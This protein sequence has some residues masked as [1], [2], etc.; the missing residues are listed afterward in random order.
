M[1]ACV[2]RQQGPP[3]GHAYGHQNQQQQGPPYGHAYG[4][5]NH[6]QA[7]PAYA[8]A[9]GPNPSYSATAPTAGSAGTGAQYGGVQEFQKGM[10]NACF[11]QPLTCALSCIFPC[12][13]ARSHRLTMLDNDITRYKCFNDRF[14][15]C[16]HCCDDCVKGNESCCLWLEACCCHECAIYTNRS[17]IMQRFNV[18]DSA[19]DSCIQIF[20]CFCQLFR[21]VLACLGYRSQ[22]LDTFVDCLYCAVYACMNSQHEAEIEYRL[23]VTT[24]EP[25]YASHMRR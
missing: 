4:H 8:A 1:R 25:D 11:T 13:K 14:S 7:P 3:Y 9:S 15:R 23:G 2:L 24:K 19:C 10:M 5:Q 20:L 17:M 22:E 21:C 6:Q 16:T 18:R 12:F